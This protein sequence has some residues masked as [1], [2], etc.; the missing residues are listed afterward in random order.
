MVKRL[1]TGVL[2]SGRGSNLAAI[3]ERSREGSI[4]VDVVVVISD[5]ED[6]AALDRARQAGVE[7]LHIPPGE[8][9]TR[10]TPEAEAEYCR[11]LDERDVDVVVLAG[12]MRILHDS[13]LRR[14][15]G[16]II[17]IHP[18]LLP[19]FPGLHAQRQAYEYGVKWS[20][21]TVHFV[22]AGVDTGPIILQKA[23]PVL[24]DDTADSLASRILEQEHQAYPEALQ[25]IAE[26]RLSIEGRRVVV[27]P[28]TDGAASRSTR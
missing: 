8:F 1:R 24:P 13:F 15:R 18:S 6:A 26:D 14:Y 28:P 22:D 7:A 2:A 27:A 21:C 20:G 23:V 4:D 25:L 10:L 3:L 12:F 16:R 11:A 19:S 9:R 5:V 17:N